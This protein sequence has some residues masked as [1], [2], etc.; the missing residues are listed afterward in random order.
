MVNR[1]EA[2]KG[3]EQAE[4]YSI[5]EKKSLKCRCNYGFQE[6]RNFLSD[7]WLPLSRERARNGG[8]YRR[9]LLVKRSATARLSG[10]LTFEIEHVDYMPYIRSRGKESI[11][12]YLRPLV[13]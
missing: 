12:S 13:L 6:L 10:D 1:Y 2:S 3:P 5:R 8:Q 11:S 7:G 9:K 4:K